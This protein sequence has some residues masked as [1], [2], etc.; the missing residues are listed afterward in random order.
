MGPSVLEAEVDDLAPAD[1]YNFRVK[2]TSAAGDSGFAE[3]TAATWGAPGAPR[4][5]VQSG[6]SVDSVTLAWEPPDAEDAAPVT[7][8]VVERRTAGGTWSVAADVVSSTLEVEVL[9]LGSASSFEF[10]VKATS[11]A[12]DSE[13]AVVEAVTSGTRTTRLTVV[14]DTGVPL[15]GGSIEWAT[16]DGRFSSSK[17]YGLTS[18]GVVDLLRTPAGPAVIKI[19]GAT[20]ASGVSATGSYRV[21]LGAD[22]GAPLTVR[23]PAPPMPSETDVRVVLP[24]GEPVVGAEV[25]VTGLRSTI[26]VGGFTFRLPTDLISSG[27]TDDSGRFLARG[28]GSGE[29]W[30]TAT[31]DDGV[32]RQTVG[33]PAS[34]GVP[35]VFTLEEMPW[36]E[37]ETETFTVPEGAAVSVPVSI[38]DVPA[39]Q[40]LAGASLSGVL[41]RIVPPPGAGKGQCDPKLSAKTNRRGEAT[42]RVC[43]TASGM[44]RLEGS[45]A[46]P[47]SSVWI[48]AKKGAPMP[49]TSASSYS[50]KLGTAR[51]SWNPP[52]YA[53]GARS[54]SYRVT[55]AY[56]GER[57]TRKVDKRDVMF[58][59]LRSATRYTASI[60]AITKFGSSKPVKLPVWIP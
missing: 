41:V 32:L 14:D 30:I 22:G 60:V 45:G 8:Y 31:Y 18:N 47:T 33:G 34:V 52:L 10:R 19:S 7:G 35:T 58:D 9:G 13:Y 3:V 5:L 39:R 23:V 48:K 26:E 54:I 42:L 57:V 2:A 37:V 25:L 15:S 44:Y 55:L 20:I 29:R 4:D 56:N 53:G 43:A 21:Q 17:A 11:A 12:G 38:S 50:A 36:I 49:V 40:R 24:N 51:L 16:T 46:V 28:F 6:R 1:S 59:G 27:R